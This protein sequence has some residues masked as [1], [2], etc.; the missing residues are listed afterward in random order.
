MPDPI[1]DPRLKRRIDFNLV[2]LWVCI[3]AGCVWL[4]L[5]LP[6]FLPLLV[7]GR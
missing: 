4:A 1:E 3:I 7:C 2:G 5:V 6:T